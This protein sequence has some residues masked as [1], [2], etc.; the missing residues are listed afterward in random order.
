MSAVV[1]EL[2]P[3][4]QYEKAN[5]FCADQRITDHVQ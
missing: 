4:Y 5:F 2:N 3:N 1:S